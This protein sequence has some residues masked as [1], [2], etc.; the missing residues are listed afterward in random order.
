MCENA[1]N[2]SEFQHLEG[3]NSVDYQTSITDTVKG[4]T[5]HPSRKLTASLS[6]MKLSP[7]APPRNEKVACWYM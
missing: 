6:D 2:M 3:K 5:E 1:V 7:Q 4:R